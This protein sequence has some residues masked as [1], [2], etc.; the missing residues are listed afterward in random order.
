MFIWH[1]AQVRR[2][3]HRRV[4]RQGHKSAISESTRPPATRDTNTC[5]PTGAGAPDKLGDEASWPIVMDVCTKQCGT[6]SGISAEPD[7]TCHYSLA[8]RTRTAG[9]VVN[10]AYRN[11]DDFPPLAVCVRV[12][13]GSLPPAS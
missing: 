10:D 4:R 3:H 13:E 7:T 1:K 8:P 6:L 2:S 5:F 11:G 9:L 12:V